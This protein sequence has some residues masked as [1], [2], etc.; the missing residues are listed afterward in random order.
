MTPL[1]VFVLLDPSRTRNLILSLDLSNCK[2]VI[3][4][5]LVLALTNHK[6]N[7]FNV[8]IPM[9]LSPKTLAKDLSLV[10]FATCPHVVTS[11][12]NFSALSLDEKHNFIRSRRLCFGCLRYCHSNRDCQRRLRCSKCDRQHPTLLHDDRKQQSISQVAP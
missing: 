10:S 8:H 2:V 9:L 12:D 4:L 3:R 1:L 5:I 11:C 7:R 6:V